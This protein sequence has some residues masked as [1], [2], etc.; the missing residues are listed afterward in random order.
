MRKCARERVTDNTGRLVTCYGTYDYTATA[1]K[2]YWWQLA[3][4]LRCSTVRAPT[5]SGTT[6]CDYTGTW[7]VAAAL[8]TGSAAESMTS[9]VGRSIKPRTDDGIG[10]ARLGRIY[11]P[12]VMVVTCCTVPA[13]VVGHSGRVIPPSVGFNPVRRSVCCAVNHPAAEGAFKARARCPRSLPK[14]FRYE[15]TTRKPY[16]MYVSI[17]I[18]TNVF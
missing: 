5:K 2:L 13:C 1:V 3:V 14:T 17:K 16:T 10:S 4:R 12:V 8:K 18:I 6:P 15:N 11:L 7:S 9:P